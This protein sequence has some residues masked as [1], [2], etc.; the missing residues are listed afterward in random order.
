[1]EET[2]K[3][4][5]CKIST[6]EIFLYSWI[7]VKTVSITAKN[8]KTISIWKCHIGIFLKGSYSCNLS[9]HE[10]GKNIASV[11]VLEVGWL[12]APLLH[13][14]LLYLHEQRRQKNNSAIFNLSI[15]PPFWISVLSPPFWICV[16]IRQ[17]WISFRILH[18]KFLMYACIYMN[19]SFWTYIIQSL[20]LDIFN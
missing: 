15:N 18:F 10:L 5:S 20:D 12:V 3:H 8:C 19:K 2:N 11:G 17:F 7:T 9:G 6:R 14:R 13:H 16:R 4:R 1:M